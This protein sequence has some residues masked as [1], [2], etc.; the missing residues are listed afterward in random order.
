MKGGSGLGSCHWVWKPGLVSRGLYVPGRGF[1]LSCK[2][3]GAR[4]AF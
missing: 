1:K 2:D 4:G 3:F